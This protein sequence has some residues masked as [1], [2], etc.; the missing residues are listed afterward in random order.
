MAP[1]RQSK[2]SRTSQEVI[3]DD[4]KITERSRR[5]Q[6]EPS[7]PARIVSIDGTRCLNCEIV[8]ISQTDAQLSVQ[9]AMNEL[10]EFFLVLSTVGKP[11]YRRCRLVW[12]RGDRI[13]VLFLF[14]SSKKRA[15]IEG[16]ENSPSSS[17]DP[18]SREI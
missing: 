1:A 3:V 5:V 17:V 11:A 16:V 6:F 2:I 4:G 13:G 8:D 12:V 15:G 7:Y 9:G 18:G 10:K 14:G